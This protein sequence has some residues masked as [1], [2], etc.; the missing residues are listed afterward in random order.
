[1]PNSLTRVERSSKTSKRPSFK[2]HH[3]TNCDGGR[4]FSRGHRMR[5]KELIPEPVMKV[6]FR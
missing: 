3:I 4:I 5:E 1:M 6:D 2:D